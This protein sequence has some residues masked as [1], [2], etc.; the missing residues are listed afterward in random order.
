MSKYVKNSRKF[1]G[2]LLVAVVLLSFVYP[3]CVGSSYRE[4]LGEVQIGSGVMLLFASSVI[5]A[6]FF[7]LLVLF[8]ILERKRNSK[9]FTC[10]KI[11]VAVGVL[12]FSPAYMLYGPGEPGYMHY[13]NGFLVRVNRE[14]AEDEV[15]QWALDFLATN[16]HG[17]GPYSI[18][19]AD[20]IP[21]FIKRIY[22]FSMGESEFEFRWSIDSRDGMERLV[23]YWGGALPG[24][25]GLEIGPK[26][27]KSESDSHAYVLE[28]KPG[29]YVWHSRE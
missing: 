16:R 28:W 11:A 19:D 10:L 17:P 29:I 13:T 22:P 5:G 20:R 2:A 26:E 12:L 4:G 3:K 14:C 27:L 18:S 15:R 24:H 25:W 6:S 23:I 21:A 8:T 1:F 7:I 9:K